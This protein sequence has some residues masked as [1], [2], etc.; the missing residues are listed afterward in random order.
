[1]REHETRQPTG[2]MLKC[3]TSLQ[4]RSNDFSVCV[5]TN[6]SHARL[7]HYNAEGVLVHIFF[8]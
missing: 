8:S 5:K 4:L 1:M 3:A 7:L 2:W 6:R